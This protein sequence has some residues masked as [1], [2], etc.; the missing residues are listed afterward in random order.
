VATESEL[1]EWEARHPDALSGA[2]VEELAVVVIGGLPEHN[3]FA[4][5]KAAIKNVIGA[6][7]RRPLSPRA[8]HS[9]EADVVSNIIGEQPLGDQPRRPVPKIRPIPPGGKL[10][11][12]VAENSWPLRGWKLRIIEAP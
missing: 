10:M 9:A 1:W 7:I 12:R 8:A 5:V 6:R 11:R 3:P 2:D 4:W